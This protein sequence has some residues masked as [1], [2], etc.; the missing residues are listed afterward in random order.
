MGVIW[1]IATLEYRL[2]ANEILDLHSYTYMEG[3]AWMGAALT[4]MQLNNKEL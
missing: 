1:N 3:I 2:E 4:G